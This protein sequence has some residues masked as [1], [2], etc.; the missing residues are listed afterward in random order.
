MTS[1]QSPTYVSKI[2]EAKLQELVRDS[3]KIQEYILDCLGYEYTG[4]ERFVRE[5]QYINGLRVDFKIVKDGE[6]IALMECKR[7]DIG[8]T[9]Y[10]R[11]IGQLLQ[12]EYFQKNDIETGEPYSQN[13]K[14]V[15]FIPSDIIKNPNYNIGTF[16]YPVS[17]QI[18]EINVDNYLVRKIA[19]DEL[20]KLA[21]AKDGKAIISQYYFRDN[22]FFELYILLQYLRYLS[23]KQSGPIN[24]SELE[25]RKLRLIETP[26]NRNWRN[27]FITLSTLGFIDRGNRVSDI[28]YFMARKS[29]GEFCYE[30]YSAY[31]KV[32]IDLIMRNLRK[33]PNM[34][35]NELKDEINNEYHGQPVLFVTDSDNRYLSSW[36]NIMRDDYQCIDFGSRSN[37]RQII[38]N[39]ETLNRETFITKI[40]SNNYAQIFIQRY[41]Q[42]IEEGKL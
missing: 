24:R 3:S 13:F 8:V 42:L 7:G 2:S 15:Y 28:G 11:G 34:S 29:Y 25:E 39:P 31:S 6:V 12:Y 5:V 35:L 40:T 36:L 18:I 26:N 32:Y 22:R 38:Y 17:T 9:D 37:E 21:T 20:Q 23:I 16:E 4:S 33:N 30:L 10:V 14:T 19:D 1:T 27:A 41:E